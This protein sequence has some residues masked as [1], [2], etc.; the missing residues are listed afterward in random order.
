[1]PNSHR[2]VLALNCAFD[3]G[4]CCR[5][6]APRHNDCKETHYNLNHIPPSCSLPIWKDLVPDVKSQRVVQ[7]TAASPSG[8]RVPKGDRA[9]P[10]GQARRRISDALHGRTAVD[11]MP[12]DVHAA[13]G[14]WEGRR[15]AM[16]Q[17]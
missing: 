5:G 3:H 7:S 11:M 8:Q 13:R 9:N 4:L 2:N 6:D 16:R 12:G 10:K 1:M 14:L 17:K 15:I